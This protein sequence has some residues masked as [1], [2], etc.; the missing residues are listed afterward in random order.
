MLAE[1]TDFAEF[2]GDVRLEVLC[3]GVF[4]VTLDLREGGERGG[5]Y[6]AGSSEAV[7]GTY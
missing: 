1:H 5:G 3:G 2:E 7:E 6:N 4:D